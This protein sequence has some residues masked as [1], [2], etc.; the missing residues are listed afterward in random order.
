MAG[1][2]ILCFYG[3]RIFSIIYKHKKLASLLSKFNPI[4]LLLTIQSFVGTSC[5]PMLRTCLC[6]DLYLNLTIICGNKMPTRCNRCFLLQILLLAQH[7][8]GI[9][10]PII[11]SSTVLYSWLCVW[12]VGCAQPANQTHNPQLH[13]IPTT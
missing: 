6:H 8:S 12:F 4:Q 3:I 11:R 2:K 5:L 1:T 7:V 13:T 10:M 9:I